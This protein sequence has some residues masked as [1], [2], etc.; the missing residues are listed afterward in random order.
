MSTG[1]WKINWKSTKYT[2]KSLLI[3]GSFRLEK[4]H[5]RCYY[6]GARREE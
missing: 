3:C 2:K 4:E 5:L 1:K 6:I